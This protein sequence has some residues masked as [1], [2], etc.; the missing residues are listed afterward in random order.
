ME[1]IPKPEITPMEKEEHQQL[2]EDLNNH[3]KEI[4][5]FKGNHMR[6]QRG[7]SGRT[8]RQDF[9]RQQRIQAIKDFYKGPGA[10]YRSMINLHR[11]SMV[12][13]TGACKQASV[14]AS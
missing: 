14:C 3:L 11:L 12:N 7:Y 2:H 9:S 6:P 13:V 5:D 1:G 8:M 4:K 10:K